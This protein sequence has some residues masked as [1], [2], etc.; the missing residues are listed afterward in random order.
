MQFFKFLEI[1]QFLLGLEEVG[2]F[3][4]ERHIAFSR[5]AFADVLSLC[6]FTH[7]QDRLD[8]LTVFDDLKLILRLNSRPEDAI[9][10]FMDLDVHEVLPDMHLA[11]L[12]QDCHDVG[13]LEG[14]KDNRLVDLDDLIKKFHCT[15]PQNAEGAISLAVER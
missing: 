11:Q 1:G 13:P 8:S 9:P 7:S 10:H 14:I 5:L 3:Y 12:H 4:H 15:H 6:R 2:K